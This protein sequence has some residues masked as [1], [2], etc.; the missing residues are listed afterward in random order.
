MKH[1]RSFLTR[2][3]LCGTAISMASALVA[4]AAQEGVAKVL[5][6]KGSARYSLGN[7]NWLP[8]NPGDIL[9]PGTLIQTGQAEG[10]YVDLA[11]MREGATAP[12]TVS[13]TMVGHLGFSAAGMVR[14]HPVAEQNT[15]RIWEN[16]LVG[17]DRLTFSD[18]GE[19]TVSDTQLDLK[20]GHILGTVKKMPAAARYEIKLPNGVAGVRGTVYDITA[21]GLIRVASGTVVYS[22]VNAQGNI[23]TRVI[24][25][26]QEY[27]PSSDQITPLAASE[28]AFIENNAAAIHGAGVLAVNPLMSNPGM[29]ITVPI[30]IVPN[31]I[32][33]VVSPTTGNL[34]PTGN[35][36][37]GMVDG[38]NAAQ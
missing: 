21:N 14:Y 8:L 31:H 28:V 13:R 7:N 36:G 2:L 11:L 18:T 30:N 19:G 16:S 12:A 23:Q 4:G 29:T 35:Q 33:N 15:I 17:I 6:I 37:V 3:V 24:T 10:T 1:T 5:R 9:R 38:S 32:V 26:G 22:F 27:N 34:G 20:A 25:G